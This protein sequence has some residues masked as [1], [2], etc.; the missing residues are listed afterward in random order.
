MTQLSTPVLDSYP[1][2]K[3]VV[4]A[5]VSTFKLDPINIILFQ[6]YVASLIDHVGDD[7]LYFELQEIYEL[8]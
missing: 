5:F 1:Q 3:P 8:T 4:L 6:E 2:H 7:D